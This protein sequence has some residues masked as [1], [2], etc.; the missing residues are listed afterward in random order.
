MRQKR[1]KRNEDIGYSTQKRNMIRSR[2]MEERKKRK[3]NEKKG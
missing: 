1:R 2:E 3:N